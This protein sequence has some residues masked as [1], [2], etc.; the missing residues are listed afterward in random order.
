MI[1]GFDAGIQRLGE[2][3][4]RDRKMKRKGEIKRKLKQKRRNAFLCAWADLSL[5]PLQN[6]GGHLV[7]F[8][9]LY[10]VCEKYSELGGRLFS[11]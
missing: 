9:L 10:C 2:F 5:L 7:R 8:G 11:S 4:A 3:G 6:N 1:P